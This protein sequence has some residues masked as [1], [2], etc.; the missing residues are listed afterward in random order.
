MPA[1]LLLS[2]LLLPLA[3]LGGPVLAAEPRTLSWEELV[4]EGAPPPPPPVA[5]HDLAQLADVLA[6]ESG[7][8]AAQQSP[9]APVV[10]ALHGQTVRL[11]GYVVP[12]G[13]DRAG[14]VREFLLV[15]YYG[16]CIHVPPPSSNQI[17]YVTSA[18]GV[19]IDALW[20]P[21]WIEGELRVEHSSSALAEAGY[22]LRADKIL[23]YTF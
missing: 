10:E 19:A 15:P 22:R 14:Q 13:L 8:P 16:A 20:Q 9:A 12:L 3:L 11:P 21:F 18:E 4:P 1:R 6:A 7:P 23:P 2:A 17:V 5:F